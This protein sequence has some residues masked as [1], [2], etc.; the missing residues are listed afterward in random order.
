MILQIA[1]PIV[2]SSEHMISHLVKIKMEDEWMQP[3]FK[4]F[5]RSTTEFVR[6]KCDT[7]HAAG[8]MTAAEYNRAIRINSLID[9]YAQKY[10][11]KTVNIF[12][13]SERKR[14]YIEIQDL[15]VNQSQCWKILGP[16]H[17]TNPY[18]FTI[19]VHRFMSGGAVNNQR[20][21][22]IKRYCNE[23]RDIEEGFVANDSFDE[24]LGLTRAEF[25]TMCA[26]SNND[27]SQPP[28]QSVQTA[29]NRSLEK[30]SSPAGQV[31]T[32]SDPVTPA[33]STVQRLTPQNV[34]INAGNVIF[35]P[36]LSPINSSPI[37]TNPAKKRKI[38]ILE[39]LAQGMQS[40][41]ANFSRLLQ[42]VRDENRGRDDSFDI[43]EG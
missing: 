24:R 37:P 16:M 10:E 23:Q 32:S 35:P 12:R 13:C 18:D 7:E 19:S 29:L 25:D 28:A 40:M 27:A 1:D 3:I 8:R 36:N 15:I 17:L 34:T 38:E 43:I 31:N 20:L 14:E 11:G 5:A 21:G 26:A 30:T 39:E 33:Q 42:E 4:Q 41:T 6:N 2:F 22:V 9:S